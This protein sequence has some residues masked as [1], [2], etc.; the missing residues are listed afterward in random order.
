MKV[1]NRNFKGARK[2]EVNDYLSIVAKYGISYTKVDFKETL[3]DELWGYKIEGIIIPVETSTLRHI[4]PNGFSSVEV[5]V[6]L[7]LESQVN[8]WFNLNDPFTS[9][10]FR[11]LL[12]GSNTTTKKIHYLSFHIDRHNGSTTNEIHPLYHLQYLQNAK[13]KPKDDFDH[14]DSLQLDIPR[15]MHFPMELILGVSFMMSNFCPDLYSN[16]IE[17]RQYINLCKLYQ[18]RVWRPYIN[19]LENFWTTNSNQWLWNPKLNCPYLL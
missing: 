16:L 13:S 15:M 4:R 19:S 18:E 14:G 1:S 3:S 10:S 17:D 5:I 6:D 8:E 9:L 12:K 7:D 11:S 2:K